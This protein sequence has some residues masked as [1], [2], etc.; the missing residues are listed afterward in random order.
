MSWFSVCMRSAGG[1]C[2]F[3]PTKVVFPPKAKIILKYK[4]MKH[5]C[6]YAGQYNIQHRCMWDTFLI[7]RSCIVSWS[8]TALRPQHGHG[9]TPSSPSVGVKSRS[10]T[11]SACVCGLPSFDRLSG[12]TSLWSPFYSTCS[13]ISASPPQPPSARARGPC[14]L[15]CERFSHCPAF[16]HPLSSQGDPLTP[17]L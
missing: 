8:F 14:N 9:N 6:N 17:P 3:L 16:P 13:S 12:Q 2:W 4:T 5:F 15:L 7:P 10:W 1:G 11:L